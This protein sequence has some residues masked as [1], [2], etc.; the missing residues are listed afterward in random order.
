MAARSR[1][2]AAGSAE[3]HRENGK[4]EGPSRKTIETIK[5]ATGASEEDIMVMLQECNNDVNE[6][7]SRLIDNPFSQVLG[8]KDKKKKKEEERKKDGSKVIE[9]RRQPN[10]GQG[11]DRRNRDRGPRN[12]LDRN[13]PDKATGR[14]R[15]QP[16]RQEEDPTPLVLNG[17]DLQPND[18]A[19]AV[20]VPEPASQR[21]T[22][23]RAPGPPG[24][25]TPTPAA[26]NVWG[27]KKN[28]ADMLKQPQAPAAPLP[29]SGSL[30]APL[31]DSSQ[32]DAVAPDQQLADLSIAD[33]TVSAPQRVPS[34]AAADTSLSALQDVQVQ[35]PSPRHQQSLGGSLGIGPV[36]QPPR[37][38]STENAAPAPPAN[39][40]GKPKP[41]ASPVVG[42][43][44]G[45][46]TGTSLL[47]SALGGS[48]AMSM[49]FSAA[50]APIAP[51]AASA[52]SHIS[53]ADPQITSS[54]LLSSGL[55]SSFTQHMDMKAP[56]PV[57]SSYQARD[58][59]NSGVQ[60]GQPLNLNF[61]N[62]GSE[63]TGSI[64]S[65]KPQQPTELEHQTSSQHV[66]SAPSNQGMGDVFQGMGFGNA[67]SVQ[68]LQQPAGS[69]PTVAAPAPARQQE[70]SA[71]QPF[72][73]S[74]S[75]QAPASQPSY[76]SHQT[77]AS[78]QALPYNLY[79]A[80]TQASYSGGYAPQ[81][82]YQ[83]PPQAQAP[84]Q[85]QGFAGYA[86]QAQQA[87]QNTQYAMPAA[88]SEPAKPGPAAPSAPEPN[89]ASSYDTSNSYASYNQSAGFKDYQPQQQPPPQ[90]QQAA[91]AAPAQPRYN[92]AN[93]APSQQ[94]QP[95][96]AGPHSTYNAGYGNASSA[97]GGT[98]SPAPSTSAPLSGAGNQG[99]FGG[100]QAAQQQQVPYGANMGYS[101]Q[102]NYYNNYGAS[103]AYGA[104]FQQPAAGYSGYGAPY[105]GQ[106]ATSGFGGGYGQGQSSKYQGGAYNQGGAYP[107]PQRG[108]RGGYPANGYDDPS[109]TGGYGHASKDRDAAY[110]QQAQSL[111]GSH[112]AA[113][114][115]QAGRDA[116]YGYGQTGQGYNAYNNANQG[117]GGYGGYGY[118]QP[119]QGYGQNGPNQSG[120]FGKLG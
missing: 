76:S 33:P 97:Y 101:H 4:G 57:A 112:A 81:S 10:T 117:Y 49:G 120:N 83:Q 62:F 19:K 8:K 103:S 100:P 70:T 80:A 107:A 24:S 90:H 18:D 43:P 5:D 92:A 37:Y 20:P 78:S 66:G 22:Y 88:A 113:P 21:T 105:G 82:A 84:A 119:G 64:D 58:T 79:P 31:P 13:G 35:G 1:R 116:N 54:G 89:Q 114:S 34:S 46:A 39:A 72:Y 110:G 42:P 23:S 36:V 51:P 52:L 95:P 111:Y 61:G 3:V 55:G 77:A 17:G 7:T 15:A 69:K 74:S 91:A 11:G 27:G 6:T 14:G 12:S 68:A 53:S 108:G 26:T 41:A 73:G 9:V 98:A 16:A 63:I 106:G 87:A 85:Q 67:F 102:P 45:Q 44:S 94:P 47:S 2:G 38:G 65:M 99:A 56:E 59:P 25:S 50:P 75:Y 29:P 86:Q 32:S 109:T 96:A 60:F 48:G 104:G 93:M 118:G 28:W 115:Y 30:Q 71:S 40:W